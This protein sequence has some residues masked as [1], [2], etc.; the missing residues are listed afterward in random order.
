MYHWCTCNRGTTLRLIC[1]QLPTSLVINLKFFFVLS[2]LY[3]RPYNL[4]FWSLLCLHLPS[5][6]TSALPSRCKVL[7]F[8]P[9]VVINSLQNKKCNHVKRYIIK[10]SGVTSLS[11][12]VCGKRGMKRQ[13]C[14]GVCTHKR[15]GGALFCVYW[16]NQSVWKMCG[17]GLVFM[18]HSTR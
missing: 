7:L 12:F 6:V 4:C 18:I 14:V 3:K 10:E 1:I 9:S 2:F 8:A 15:G 16:G 17:K 13:S 5:P 11:E